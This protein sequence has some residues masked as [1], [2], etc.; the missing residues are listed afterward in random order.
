MKKRTNEEKLELIDEACDLFY[1]A[2]KKIEKA[3]LLFH[4]CGIETCGGFDDGEVP[5]WETYGCNV[6]LYKGIKRMEEITGTKGYFPKDYITE[7]TDKSR[8]LLKYNDLVFL[9]CS[10]PISTKHK[11]R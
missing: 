8:M 11:Y 6:Q 2:A 5:E 3:R 4:L 7:K 9:Q 1:E 10:D